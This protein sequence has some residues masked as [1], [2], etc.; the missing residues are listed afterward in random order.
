MRFIGGVSRLEVVNVPLRGLIGYLRMASAAR[1]QRLKHHFQVREESVY[2]SD[3]E[4]RMV[5]ALQRLSPEESIRI[6]IKEVDDAT[7]ANRDLCT[8]VKRKASAR[9]ND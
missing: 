3:R 5:L 1:H 4:E 6:K 7:D 9:R 8:R 2:R